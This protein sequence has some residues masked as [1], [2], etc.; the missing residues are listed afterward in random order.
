M[1]GY[2]GRILFVDCTTAA[3]RV[4]PL[5][6]LTARTL[7]GG[8]GLAARILYDHVPAGIDAFD[9]ANAVVFAVGPITDTTVPGNSRACAAAKS[10]LTG[11]FFDSTFGGRLPATLKRTGFDAVVLTGRAPAPCYVVV[12]ERGAT[13]KPATAAWGRTTRDTVAMLVEAEGAEA[14]AI[15]IGQAGERQ[16]R[17]A[18]MAHY[19]KNREAVSG[20]GGLGAVLGSKNV[21][22]LVVK[23]ARKTEIADPAALKALLEETREPLK[24]GTQALT[25]F[26]TPFLVGPIN[27]LGALGSYNLRTEV[28]AQARAIGGESM[29]EHYHDRDTTCLKCPV[30]CGKQYAIREGEFAGTRAKM[31]EYESIFALGPMLGIAEP[32]ALIL[33]NDLC[34]QHGLDTISM[35]VTLALVCEALERGWLAAAEVGV[36]F[37]WGDW[38][39]MLRLVELTARRNGFGNRLAEGAWRLAESIHPEAT[40]LVYAVKRLELPAHSARALKGLSI[41]YATATRGGSHHDT[42]PT[43]QYAPTF[44]RRST[45]DKPSFAARSQHFTAVGDS[46]VM[47]RFTSER[48]F[49]LFVDE[50]YARMVRAVT[51]W[52][53]NVE[54]L[55]R[56]GER[57]VNLERLFNVREGVRRRQD[58]LPWRVMHEPIAEG[59]SAGMYCPP[60]ELG[61]MLDDYYALR[62]WDADGVPTRARLSALGL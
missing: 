24:K 17:F 38:R 12:D 56:I 7:L 57:I 2:G 59:P 10:P 6:E 37:G 18:A 40:R 47:C 1:K 62:G 31:P 41:G 20:R 44:D 14:D 55:E 9:P 32:E 52:D 13:L 46:L 33:A 11:L 16:V 4:E 19:W 42:R 22:A 3:S 21:K 49:G 60:A 45:A 48:G 58:V 25:T 29:K 35:G 39:G 36:P 61:A 53:V 34:D 43:P 27:A 30:A 54:E 50:P 5:S 15:A 28:F 8:N 23:G 26:G 51:G